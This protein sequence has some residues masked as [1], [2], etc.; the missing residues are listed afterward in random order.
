MLTTQIDFLMTQHSVFENVFNTSSELLCIV[1][2][3]EP[4]SKTFWYFYNLVLF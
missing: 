1:R 3:F 4:S 2:R